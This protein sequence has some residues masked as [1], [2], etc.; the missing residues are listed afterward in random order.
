M[1]GRLA[2]KISVIAGVGGGIG[3]ACALSF[4]REGA[5][6]VGCDV[7]S[8]RANAIRD[9]A[10]R[11]GITMD[12][13]APVDLAKPDEVTRFID[14]VGRRYGRI[15]VLV[16]ATAH[17][18]MAWIEAMT[19]DQ[20]R[21]VLVNEVDVVFQTCRAAWPHMKRNGGSIINFS[22]VNAW[23]AVEALPSI[24]HTAGKAAVLGM[25]RQLAMEGAPHGIRANTVT[26]GLIVTPA[27]E[28][29]MTKRPEFRKV[30]DRKIML[31][32]LGRPQDIANCCV[33]LGS[34][35]SEWVTGAD[36]RIDGGMMAW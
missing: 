15:D 6:V 14:S 27:T 32:R 26:P 3:S 18:H 5:K 8:D 25:T 17:V 16:N 11:H 2:D 4:A 20:F 30:L 31:G 10:V 29:V 22:S 35:E 21:E 13:L 9:E 1:T 28:Q 36:F 24:A 33:F 34:D 7:A 19:N 23:M 12:V